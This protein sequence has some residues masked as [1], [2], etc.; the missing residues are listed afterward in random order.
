M[1][2]LKQT[3]GFIGAG[4][5]ARAILSGMLN[6]HLINSTQAV[7]SDAVPEQLE[8]IEQI[9]QPK[10][11]ADNSEVVS[12]A[13]VVLFAVKPYQ[14]DAVVN[15]IKP[16]ARPAQ[17]F[18]TICAGITTSFI[19]DRLGEGTRVVR[20]MPNTP[21]LIQCGSAAVSPG[22]WA[23]PQD[24]QLVL[25]IF[26]SVGVAVQLTE[27]K[28]NLVTGLTGSGPAYIFYFTE[29][30]IQAGMEL[31]L[32]QSDATELVK[33]MVY[34]AARMAKETDVPL[35]ELR[36]Q[37]TTKGGTTEAGLRQLEEGDLRE[38]VLSCIRAATDR[39][40]DLAQGK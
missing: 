17:L 6:A 8:K 13:D 29:L 19:E 38:L 25:R 16:H 28:M 39:G 22:R 24:V 33:Q 12:S 4:N 3:F 11:A 15:E 30:L 32:T 26:N 35:H 1:A 37:V 40:A 9:A 21:A 18:I 23:T 36:Q 10:I 27:D 5:M 2:H 34:G 14:M 20:V 7:V 31:G